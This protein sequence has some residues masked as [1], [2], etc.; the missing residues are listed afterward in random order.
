[1]EILS[2]SIDILPNTLGNEQLIEC[3]DYPILMAEDNPDDILI[4]Q[5]AWKKGKIK[6]KL[7]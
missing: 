4:T 1:M 7:Y 3:R 2:Q 6:N 5:R